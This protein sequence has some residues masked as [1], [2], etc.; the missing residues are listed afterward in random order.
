MEVYTDYPERLRPNRT[1]YLGEEHRPLR[2][3]HARW[4]DKLLLLAFQGIDDR[5]EALNLRNQMLYVRAEE[6]PELPSG[7]YYHHQLIG[8][9]VIDES[10]QPVGVLTEILET[11]ANDVFV[12]EPGSG[13]AVLLPVIESVVLEVNLEKGEITVRPQLWD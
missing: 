11:G 9:R 10:N 8:L 13:P 2:I 5:D 4:K 7:D 3:V 6:S 1:V 12:V